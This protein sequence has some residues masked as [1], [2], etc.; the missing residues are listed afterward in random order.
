MSDAQI[1]PIDTVDNDREPLAGQSLAVLTKSMKKS[2]LMVPIILASDMK[3]IDGLRRLQVLQNLGRTTVSAV[4]TSTLEET[5]DVL[6]QATTHGVGAV[7]LTPRRAWQIFAATGD[8]QR[9][10]GHRMRHRRAGVPRDVALEPE[11]RAREL[12]ATALGLEGESFLATSVLIYKAVEMNTDPVKAEVLSEIIDRLEA[13]TYTLYQARGALERA[14]KGKSA[15]RESVTSI[16]DQRDALATALS[17]LRGTIHG[18]E[19]LGDISEQMQNVEVQMYL[20]GF[21]EGTR[22]LRRFINTLR[23]RATEK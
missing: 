23:K 16:D 1:I 20:R 19:R 21:E 18:I 4:I 2:G 10:R 8:Q 7:P 9:E 12:L 5:A 13:G 11:P 3:L 15:H 14:Q 22:V 6:R 17:Q